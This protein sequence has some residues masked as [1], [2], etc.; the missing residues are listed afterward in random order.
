M[1]NFPTS[2]VTLL[3][4]IKDNGV[5]LAMKKRGFGKDKWNGV[6]GKVEPGE[7]VEAACIRECQEEI[8]VT[9]KDIKKVAIHTFQIESMN[10]TIS[11]HTYITH[12]YDGTPTET[13]EM[14][15]RWFKFAD[16]PYNEMWQDDVYW[17]PAVLAG[18]KL[19][20][21]FTFDQDDNMTEVKIMEVASLAI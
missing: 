1:T 5:L 6:G 14:A 11:V 9:P 21:H 10:E 3:F 17:L 4:L 20:T 7:S 18:R 2:N 15:P 19:N 13:E 12:D 16:I 8:L